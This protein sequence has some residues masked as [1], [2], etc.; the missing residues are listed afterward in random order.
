MGSLA[1]VLTILMLLPAGLLWTEGR[2][3]GVLFEPSTIASNIAAKVLWH[4]I[5]EVGVLDSDISNPSPLKLDRNRQIT[6]QISRLSN[7][8]HE[9]QISLTEILGHRMLDAVEDVSYRNR[10]NDKITRIV[11]I[12]KRIDR[13]ET[14][15]NRLLREDSAVE[16]ITLTQFAQATIDLSNPKSVLELLLELEMEITGDVGLIA[17]EGQDIFSQLNLISACCEQS[18]RCP[19][20]TKLQDHCAT[21]SFTTHAHIHKPID[22]PCIGLRVSLD[23]QAPQ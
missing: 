10:F 6:Q 20:Q 4:I 21:V 12:L 11:S 2:A 13:L 7:K 5:Q 3:D 16:Q 22:P 8:L 14:K 9:S 23:L 17:T 1:G 15:M 18:V 19:P